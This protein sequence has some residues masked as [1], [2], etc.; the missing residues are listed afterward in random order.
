MA[1]D[2]R[3]SPAIATASQKKKK[4][5]IISSLSI[6]TGS[7]L[8]TILRSKGLAISL[9]LLALTITNRPAKAAQIIDANE[10]APATVKISKT[11]LNRLVA[12]GDITAIPTRDTLGKD[13]VSIEIEGRNA[14]VR[15][16]PNASPTEYIQIYVATEQ[17]T[18]P[19]ILI[20]ADIP[21]ET[22]IIRGGAEDKKSAEA[23]ERSHDYE[24]ALK[25]LI[26][27]MAQGGPA[28]PGYDK[29]LP[30]K[31]IKLQKWKETD[32]A[33]TAE[34]RGGFMVG[35][36]YL[37]R[38]IS[39]AEIRLKGQEFYTEGVRAVAIESESLPKGATTRVC[40]ISERRY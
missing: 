14:Y 6:K 40:V 39:D 38:N 11:Q 5:L 37:V 19:L 2:R 32:I 7:F 29:Q 26:R 17:G 13:G 20:P 8:L 34:Y 21:G 10:L 1:R 16:L 15:L 3:I 27:A 4:L 35:R 28:P 36:V 22:I 9:A 25:N 23:W 24:T 33:L 12:P 30:E 18:Y 31:N